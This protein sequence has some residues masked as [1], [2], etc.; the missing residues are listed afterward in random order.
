MTGGGTRRL[1]SRRKG[2]VFDHAPKPGC[3]DAALLLAAGS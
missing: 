2:G 3:R 1:E